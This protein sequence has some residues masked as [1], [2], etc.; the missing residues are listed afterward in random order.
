MPAIRL[1]LLIAPL[2]LRAPSRADTCSPAAA[3]NVPVTFLNTEV[4]ALSDSSADSLA[5]LFCA[6]SFAVSAADW[7]GALPNTK[8]LFNA[9]KRLVSASFW[10]G[11]VAA[12]LAA[13][14]P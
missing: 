7:S 4:R 8:E 1:F 10:F 12:V 5:V 11:A 3:D 2:A 14:S 13:V 6:A 9:A